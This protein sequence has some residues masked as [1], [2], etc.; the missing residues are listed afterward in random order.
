VYE[1]CGEVYE[2]CGE[3]HEVRGDVHNEAPRRGA[4]RST[5]R[6]VTIQEQV[7]PQ[8]LAPNERMTVD[9]IEVEVRRNRRRRTRIGLA[10]DPAGRVILEAPMDA[11]TAELSAVV[12]EHGRWLR[13]RLATLREEAAC[14]SP[15]TYVSGELL[16]YLGEAYE[17]LVEPGPRRVS[18]REKS[19]QQRLFRDVRGVVGNIVVR[20]PDTEPAQ[21]KRALDRWYRR[22][23]QQCFGDRLHQFRML[24]WMPGWSGDWGV[25]VMRSQWGSCS[26]SGRIV[27][28]THL[29]KVP[30]RLIDYVVLH[31]LCHLVHHDHS[32]RFYGLMRAHMPDWKARRTELDAYLPLLVHD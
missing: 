2:V 15:P 16:Q 22:E 32:H 24:P 1:V 30:E 13:A 29:V 19:G 27:L 26:V 4:Q 23:A 7:V 12:V 3:V 31:E 21:V 10:F 17:L 8:A 14:V 5:V 18:R 20:L 6:D 28:N 9:S 25:R 11:T